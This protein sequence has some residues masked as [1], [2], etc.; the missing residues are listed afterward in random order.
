VRMLQTQH[1]RIF[2]RKTL[3]EQQA[4]FFFFCGFIPGVLKRIV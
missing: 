1:T 2:W 4:F 3:F